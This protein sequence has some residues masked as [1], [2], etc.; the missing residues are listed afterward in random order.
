MADLGCGC[1]ALSIGAA[2]L[3]ASLVI[4]FEID[5]DALD[6]FKENV[7]DHELSNVDAILSD[8]QHIPER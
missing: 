6:V 8:I 4:G 1:G 3:N 7:E 5:E 2:V